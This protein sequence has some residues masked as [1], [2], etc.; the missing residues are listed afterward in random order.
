MVDAMEVLSI[1]IET[2]YAGE[3]EYPIFTRPDGKTAQCAIILGK[4]GSGKSTLARALSTETGKT[5][6]L[7]KNKEE[8]DLG[9]D[10]SNVHVF[11]EEYVIK[12]FRIYEKASLEPI[13]LLGNVGERLDRLAE[14]EKNIESCG[15]GISSLKDDI[16]RRVFHDDYSVSTDEVCD[17]TIGEYVYSCIENELEGKNNIDEHIWDNDPS[18]Y[19]NIFEE[20]GYTTDTYL[21]WVAL[22]YS[23]VWSEVKEEFDDT[24]EMGRLA[25]DGESEM[26][27]CHMELTRQL[28]SF[29]DANNNYTSLGISGWLLEQ[30]RK[31]AKLVSCFIYDIYPNL[32]TESEYGFSSAYERQKFQD[33]KQQRMSLEAQYKSEYENLIIYQ[34][35]YS[36]DSVIQYINQLLHIVFGENNICLETDSDF[37][38]KV[39]VGDGEISPK[40]LS[41]GEQNILSLC[42]FFASLCEDENFDRLFTK[43]QIVI[44][45]DP[46]SSFDDDNKYGVTSLLG[47]LCQSI[48]D[49]ESKTKLIIMTHDSSFA[50]NMSRMIKAIDS[51]KLF[52]WEIQKDSSESLKIS[53]FEDIDRYAGILR[54]MYDFA[55]QE[56]ESLEAPP[57]NDVRRVW[58][59][60]LMFELGMASI[61]E[62][63]AMK[64]LSASFAKD[65]RIERFVRIFIPQLFIN[66]DS[67]AK[68]QVINGNL[69][70]TPNLVGKPY[71]DFVKS[72]VCCMHIIAP[73][74][75]A[76]RMKKYK[77][78][79]KKILDFV[80]AL[81]KLL[82]DVLSITDRAV[83]LETLEIFGGVQRLHR[84]RDC[85]VRV[86]SGI[87][88]QDTKR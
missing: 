21:R 60:F 70:L 22:D 28:D 68:S 35:E 31:M 25:W 38:Y 4:N 51:T 39:K 73:R 8:E 6:F 62:M 78:E 15:M 74:H 1:K 33:L 85:R 34:K 9:I 63:G 87:R 86:L 76:W 84:A 2:E 32:H 45:D 36:V 52:C 41:I 64:N 48:L 12:N 80:D 10:F 16:L 71:K 54:S 7:N 56:E 82:K 59:A 29:R 53:K 37:G 30:R 19:I 17:F 14:I 72:I 49:K 3:K 27:V 57:P 61:A 77:G 69:Y 88:R 18:G 40:R 44:L 58:E 79:E 24:N 55:L 65:Q 20:T 83:A 5:K 42:Y 43:N 23:S 81:D 11:N 26:R 13:I 46:V 66:T 50:L 67:H 75:I 47:Y